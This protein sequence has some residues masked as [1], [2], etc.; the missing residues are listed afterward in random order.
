[1]LTKV[2]KCAKSDVLAKVK[3]LKGPGSRFVFVRNRS[4]EEIEQNIPWKEV[5]LVHCDK[6]LDMF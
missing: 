3:E 1:M 5:R 2:D 6:R 4:P